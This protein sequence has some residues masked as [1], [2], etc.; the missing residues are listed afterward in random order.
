MK[1]SCTSIEH[2]HILKVCM[3]ISDI[4]W[5]HHVASSFTPGPSENA[6]LQRQRSYPRHLVVRPLSDDQSRVGIGPTVR[7]CE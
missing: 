2:V 1:A 3:G 7:D 6:F 5:C 4:T